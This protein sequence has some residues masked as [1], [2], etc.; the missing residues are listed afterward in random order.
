MTPAERVAYGALGAG[1]AVLGLRG[2]HPVQRL[3]LSAAGVVVAAQAITGRHPV[4]TALKI[5]QG[6]DGEVRVS[7]AV[8]IGQ[9][10][11]GLYAR[12][13]D[14]AS[15][16]ALMTHLEK[17]E[18]LD[19]KRSR[20]TVKAPAGTHVSWE[21]EIM[22]EEPGRR[23]AWASLPGAAVENSGEVLFRPAPGNRG[24]ELVVH[25]TYKPLGGAAGAVVARILGQ[26]PGQQ[27]RDDLMR[28]KREQELGYAPTARGQS[29]GRAGAGKGTQEGRV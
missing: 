4:A 16:P 23:L 2:G 18:V 19:E 22:A 20:W 26:E 27:L 1:L 21:A 7:D 24:T 14:L 10:P 12:W 8:T 28:F 3:L 29:S 17:V 13:R 5:N 11:E 25:L 9:G 15:L 6:A